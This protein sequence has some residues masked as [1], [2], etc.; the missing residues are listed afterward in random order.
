M[1]WPNSIPQMRTMDCCN[2]CYVFINL[3]THIYRSIVIL[4]VERASGVS[5]NLATKSF[6]QD[7]KGLW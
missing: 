7:H 1:S 2:T 5:F 4:L 3:Y 6:T